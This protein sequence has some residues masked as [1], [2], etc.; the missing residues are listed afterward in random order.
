MYSEINPTVFFGLLENLHVL[1]LDKELTNQADIMD[2]QYVCAYKQASS[3][4]YYHLSSICFTSTLFAPTSIFDLSTSRVWL[5]P[6]PSPG[7]HAK[8]YNRVSPNIWQV[9][10]KND[11]PTASGLSNKHC[12]SRDASVVNTNASWQRHPLQLWRFFTSQWQWCT[13]LITP[14]DTEYYSRPSLIPISNC[15]RWWGFGRRFR[16]ISVGIRYGYWYWYWYRVRFIFTYSV[17]I[18]LLILILILVS[19]FLT[20]LLTGIDVEMETKAA[21]IGMVIMWYPILWCNYIIASYPPLVLFLF[22]LSLLIIFSIGLLSSNI[23]SYP[24]WY[25][26]PPPVFSKLWGG[27]VTTLAW[28][29]RSLISHCQFFILHINLIIQLWY[30]CLHCFLTWLVPEYTLHFSHNCY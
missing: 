6:P 21:R 7:G 18:P 8:S 26:P 27:D 2:I 17:F 22:L 3:T 28:I 15:K 19:F 11:P 30:H 1:K 23:I 10:P 9:L 29:L 5:Q 13:Y 16:L 4:I 25:S 20:L 14:P 24:Q 12:T